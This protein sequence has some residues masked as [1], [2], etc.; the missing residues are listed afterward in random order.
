MTY[1]IIHSQSRSYILEV[2]PNEHLDEAHE[3]LW[4]IISHCPQTEF[5]YERLINLSKMWFFK[6][7][8]HCSYSQN[9]EK[10]ISL[11]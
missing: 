11:F 6:H 9:N 4:K 10:L 5:E 3:R 7:R 8:Y 1:V 2:L